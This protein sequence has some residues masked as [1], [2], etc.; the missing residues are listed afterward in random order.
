ML[1]AQ[2]TISGRDQSLTRPAP[3]SKTGLGMSEYLLRYVLT[4]F[5]WVSPS[6]SATTRESMR[7]SV[8]TRGATI[9]A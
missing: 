4:V 2:A 9:E 5:L 6:I 3:S 7:S 1:L 8:F